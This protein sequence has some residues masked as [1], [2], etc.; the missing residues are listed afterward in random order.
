MTKDYYKILG[1]PRNATKEDIK[2][3]Y[4]RLAHLYHPDKAGGSGERFKEINEAYQVLGDE[5]KR[6]QYDQFGRVF[7][8]G[9]PFGQGGFNW[10]GAGGFRF[11]EDFK[12]FAEFD[13]SDVFDEMLGGFGFGGNG[14]SRSK[15][16]RDLHIDLDIPFE[17]MVSGGKHEVL[18]QKLGKCGFCGGTG[19]EDRNKMVSC[20]SC[21][22]SGRVEKTQRTFLGVFSQVSVCTECH[23]RGEKPEKACKTCG[24]RGIHEQTE[25]IEV[26]VPA[27]VNDSDLLKVSGRGEASA[28]G[29]VPGDLYV[30]VHVIPSKIYR[31]QDNDIIMSL[32]VKLTDAVLGAKVDVATLDGKISV[33]IP[34]GTESGDV[35]KVRGKG[36]PNASGYGRGDLM[37]EIKVVTPKKLSRKARELF[38]YLRKEE[39]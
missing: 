6:A 37:I 36:V 8:G 29:G 23:G 2:K 33:K 21:G 15:K 16:G 26:F 24:G 35:L 13:F 18:L 11:G 14:R 10:G 25:R 20:G 34:E 7:E 5:K 4:R 30:K 28:S 32:P 39:M 38:E 19:A 22:G 3:A 9:A 1:I 17:E 27:G 31:R 12:N